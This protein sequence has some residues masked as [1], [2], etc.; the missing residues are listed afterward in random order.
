MR[1]Y[2][3]PHL[4]VNVSIF[5]DAHPN[6]NNCINAVVTHFAGPNP[7]IQQIVEYDLEQM[8]VPV[9][10]EW[11]KLFTFAVDYMNAKGPNWSHSV[12]SSNQTIL[13]DE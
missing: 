2:I 10:W 7:R 13:M 3:P 12:A 6:T 4:L 11:D 8:F 1:F 9:D 5:E